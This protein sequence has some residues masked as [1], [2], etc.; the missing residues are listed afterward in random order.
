VLQ[1]RSAR[2][3]ALTAAL[4]MAAFPVGADAATIIITFPDPTTESK[5][6]VGAAGAPGQDGQ[7]V[8]AEASGT[9]TWWAT[10]HIDVRAFGG[11]GGPAGS[12]PLRPGNGGGATVSGYGFS[13]LGNRVKVIGAA[14]GGAGGPGGPSLPIDHPDWSLEIPRSGGDGASIELRD[15]VDGSTTGDLILAQTATGGPAGLGGGAGGNAL[16]SLRRLV[17]TKSLDLS[18][19]A[20]GGG[21]GG[22]AAWGWGGGGAAQASGIG[23]NSAGP[24]SVRARAE[25]GDGGVGLFGSP[26]GGHAQ[27]VAFGSTQASNHTVNVSGTCTPLG[28]WEPIATAGARGGD[29]GAIL[30]DGVWVGGRAGDAVSESVGIAHG[31]SLVSVRDCA[32][33]GSAISWGPRPKR[34]GVAGDAWSTASASGAGTRFVTA[35][36]SATGGNGYDPIAPTWGGDARARSQ[37]WGL[38]PVYADAESR[39][40][41]GGVI[42]E[43]G[44]RRPGG[45][46]LAA[47]QGIGSSGEAS[48]TASSNGKRH[49][50]TAHTRVQSVVPTALARVGV[51]G[52]EAPLPRVGPSSARIDVLADP[53]LSTRRGVRDR[54]RFE[55][56]RLASRSRIEL[57]HAYQ[58]GAP[59]ILAA[60][61]RVEAIAPWREAG[62]DDA[63]VFVAF[64]DPKLSGVGFESMRVTV[65]WN[66][67]RYPIADDFYD[68]AEDAVAALESY[69]ANL[70]SSTWADV[71]VHIELRA[72]PAGARF[73]ADLLVGAMDGPT[74][75]GT[76]RRGR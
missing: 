72:R 55:R 54:D 62:G 30:I 37:A 41:L 42:A 48:A 15:A 68:R 14:T 17:S 39:A 25:G 50:L 22:F 13:T 35:R 66:G 43:G 11:A 5:Q 9:D 47:A 26:D 6:V 10:P 38:G 40:G 49:L 56:A 74:A 51:G 52:N 45:A 36:A 59:A 1:T 34:P 63:S 44:E 18:A 64:A 20:M 70:G 21:P 57:A 67:S 27:V 28:S 32:E 53:R 58:P 23:S 65:F 73:S 7:A 16:S 60:A 69:A 2:T 33:G 76:A 71:E 12:D 75:A 3:A 31:D 8:T 29:A 61:L 46:A 24:V 4:A 19:R